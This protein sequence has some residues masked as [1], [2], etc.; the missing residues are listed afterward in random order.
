MQLMLIFQKELND[1]EKIGL[2]K[3]ERALKTPQGTNII[4]EDRN[5]AYNM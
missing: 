2:F 3:E 1:I 5:N 4:T